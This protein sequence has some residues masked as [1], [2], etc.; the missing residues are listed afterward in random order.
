MKLFKFALVVLVL[1]V[2]FLFAQPSFADKPKYK[3]NP[4]YIELT[5]NLD[6]LLQARD[7]QTLPEGATAEEVQQR[8]A[9]LQFQKYIME[10]GEKHAECRNE[11][12]KTIAIYGPK[13]KKSD[14]PYD[15]SLYLL[16]DGQ[17]TDDDW[18]CEGIYLP[19]DVQ[20]AG[21][22]LGSPVAIKVLQGTQLVVKSNPDT[23]AFEFNLPPAKVL[24]ADEI[25]WNIP[26]VSQAALDLQF[27]TAP[28]D[29]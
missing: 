15:N 19:N 6:S 27:P 28:I 14:S 9:Q 3:E 17:T 8:I 1:L 22:D 10:R 29:D 18:D 2:N 4:D 13:S 12:G 7:S 23:G 20:V 11:T 5:Q 26:D 16:P 21:L 25:N 24:K